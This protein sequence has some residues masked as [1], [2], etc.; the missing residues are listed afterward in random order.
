[1]S[2]HRY[3]GGVA[4][5]V[6]LVISIAWAVKVDLPALVLVGLAGPTLTSGGLMWLRREGRSRH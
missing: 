4:M 5:V 6:V 2:S 1:M 3:R